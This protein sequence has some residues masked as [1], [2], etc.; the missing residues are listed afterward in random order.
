MLILYAHYLQLISFFS[1]SQL[2]DLTNLQIKGNLMSLKGTVTIDEIYILDSS[3]WDENKCWEKVGGKRRGHD[4]GAR[5]RI[6]SKCGGEGIGHAKAVPGR[7]ENE[8]KPRQE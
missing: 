6:T 3:L 7:A 4:Q 8:L 2:Q 1:L 5:K